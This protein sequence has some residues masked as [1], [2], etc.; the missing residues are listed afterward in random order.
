MPDAA[1]EEK[2]MS[3]D[4]Y[5]DLAELKSH[6]PARA[7]GIKIAVSSSKERGR[8]FFGCGMQE[9]ARLIRL[10][11]R[12]PKKF[13]SEGHETGRS[14]ISMTEGVMPRARIMD[15]TRKKK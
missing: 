8:K 6:P 11:G 10:K 12:G 7:Q 13:G 1:S 15:I 9:I 3:R 14:G 2:S 4:R 5:H